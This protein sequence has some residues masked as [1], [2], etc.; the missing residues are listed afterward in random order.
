MAESMVEAERLILEDNR[1]DSPRMMLLK[2]LGVMLKM[3]ENR[4]ILRKIFARINL[5]LF[6]STLK[7][8]SKPFIII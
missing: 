6:L 4:F 8:P 7:L 3:V 1:R 2:G 5:E